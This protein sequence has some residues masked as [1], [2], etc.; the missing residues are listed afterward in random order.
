MDGLYDFPERLR[1]RVD[2]TLLPGERIVWAGRP[3]PRRSMLGAL[4]AVLFGLPWTAISGG[5]MAAALAAALGVA[6]TKGASGWPAFALFLF[7][8]PFVLI[9][10]A[11]LG[12]PYWARREAAH[13][14]VIVTD[15]RVLQLTE[16]VG[17]KVK[18]LSGASL[19]GAETI[20]HKD[21]AGTVK[22]LGPIGR[23]SDG[24]PKTDDLTLVGVKDPGG[25]ERA[26]W[27]LIA[28]SRR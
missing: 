7:T 20:L 13:S 22:A 18:A 14:G 11:L 3:D 8:I 25:A 9:G 17:S 24:D 12:A 10:L 27:S 23:D 15:R 21:G 26:I 2:A 16:D 5:M 28:A 6:D 1:R 19:R 4:P